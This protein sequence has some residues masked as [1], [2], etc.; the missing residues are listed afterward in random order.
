MVCLTHISELGQTLTCLSIIRCMNS[1]PEQENGKN[2]TTFS[3]N[4]DLLQTSASTI[5]CR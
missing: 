5:S 3:F 4:I 1:S 2:V